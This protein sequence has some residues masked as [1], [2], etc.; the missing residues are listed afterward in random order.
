MRSWVFPDTALCRHRGETCKH[1]CVREL[2]LTFH[3]HIG[4]TWTGP[5]FKV[6]FESPEKRGVEPA[7]PKL[8]SQVRSPLLR[9]SDE[10]SL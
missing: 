4:Q 8:G 10:T 1:P 7:T 2:G 6:L 9:P 3:Q 5:R